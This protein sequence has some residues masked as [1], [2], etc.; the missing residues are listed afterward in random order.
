MPTIGNGMDTM[1]QL[2]ASQ[3][4]GQLRTLSKAASTTFPPPPLLM[5]TCWPARD[6]HSI[7]ASYPAH[8]SVK[9]RA[10]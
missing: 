6:N 9:P 4:S 2:L 5:L 8:L 7:R 3:E 10:A 1:L